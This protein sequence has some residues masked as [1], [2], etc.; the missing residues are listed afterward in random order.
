MIN[1]FSTA[2]DACATRAALGTSNKS[3]ATR[4]LNIATY[5]I[6][7]ATDARTVSTALGTGN[8]TAREF[9]N[10]ALTFFTTADARSIITALG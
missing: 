4:D 2:T 1:G 6:F 10:T 8:G 5:A 9:Y 3:C 7:S